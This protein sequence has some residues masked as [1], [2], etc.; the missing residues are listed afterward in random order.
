MSTLNFTKLKLEALLVANFLWSVF[1]IRK[2]GKWFNEGCCIKLVE[3]TN[4]SC[5]TIITWETELTST[6]VKALILYI[7]ILGFLKFLQG[8]LVHLFV[9]FVGECKNTSCSLVELKSPHTNNLSPYHVLFNVIHI[10]SLIHLK[11]CLCFCFVN[12]KHKMLTI[13]MECNYILKWISIL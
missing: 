6:W 3:Y 5:S 9:D 12:P 1:R 2:S 8:Q 7:N 11:S 4:Q 13:L 10:V